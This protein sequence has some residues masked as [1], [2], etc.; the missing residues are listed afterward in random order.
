MLQHLQPLHAAYPE[1]AIDRKI[2]LL[3]SDEFCSTIP[4]DLSGNEQKSNA[5]MFEFQ[6]N[7]QMAFPDDVSMCQ[8]YN[9]VSDYE[10]PRNFNTAVGEDDARIR[11][12]TRQVKHEQP[13]INAMLQLQGNARRRILLARLVMH[14]LGSK[15]TGTKDGSF[16]PEDRNSK[17]TIAGV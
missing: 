11:K 2:P 17:P 12:R 14:R 10:Q 4:S 13:N 16:S 7:S 1:E 5:S 9:G 15:E 3:P 8:V 6:N